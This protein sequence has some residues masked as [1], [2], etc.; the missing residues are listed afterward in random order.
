M[1]RPMKNR[2]LATMAAGALLSGCTL[3]GGGASPSPAERVQGAGGEP[4]VPAEAEFVRRVYGGSVTFDGNRIALTLELV[5]DGG[6][7]SARLTIPDLDLD[8]GGAGEIR[9]EEVTLELTYAGSC[10]GSLT[11]EG[12]FREVRRRI[13]GRLTARDCTGEESG[14]VVLL[15]RPTGNGGR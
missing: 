11:L 1:T 8:A 15:V 9:G 2:T 13:Q 4:A 12:D 5:N 3:V 6:E 14:A 7:V 10:A